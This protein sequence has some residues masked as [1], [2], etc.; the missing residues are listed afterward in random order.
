[1]SD[2]RQPRVSVIMATYNRAAEVPNALRSVREQDYPDLE[3]VVVDGNS[4]D[5]TADVLRAAEAA[6]EIDHLLIEPD[7]G[8]Y[9]AW[10]KGLRLATGEW[11]L[12]LG[13]DD[14]YAAPDSIST[15][16]A[17]SRQRPDANLVVGRAA[18]MHP[19]GTIGA[20]IGTRWG[21]R[22]I[23]LCMTIAHPATL[24]HRSI[25]DS[26][27]DFST[28]LGVAADY[29]LYLRARRDIRAVSI[30]DVIVHFA[31][32]GASTQHFRATLR[33]A[34]AVQAQREGVGALRAA[35]QYGGFH[36]ALPVRERLRTLRGSRGNA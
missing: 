11:L 36:L 13:S 27:G 20:R 1:M 35:V 9:D 4:T 21:R 26:Y 2:D 25:I 8:I 14:E 30:D 24:T 12:F 15:L 33:S 34:R 23:E 17:A 29:D 6:G 28:T 5:G 32:G 16:V 31:S 3:L 22:L 7:K 18:I 10:N 19:D